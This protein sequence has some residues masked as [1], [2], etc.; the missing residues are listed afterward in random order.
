MSSKHK[1]QKDDY[2][3]EIRKIFFIA[4]VLSVN[5]GLGWS[6]GLL[7]TAEFPRPVY[8]TF[9]YLFSI[10]VGMQGVLI[11]ILHCART[12]A[13]REI[14][15]RW[16]LVICMCKRPEE[17]K[18]ITRQMATNTGGGTPAISRK[19]APMA[20]PSRALDK[21]AIPLYMQHYTRQ[22]S[23][24]D[25]GGPKRNEMYKNPVHGLDDM[26]TE[27]RMAPSLVFDDID[28]GKE[29]SKIEE[30]FPR[31]DDN[32]QESSKKLSKKESK[33]QLRKQESTQLRK[34]ESK[35]LRKQESKQLRKQESKQLWKQESKQLWKQDS[36]S[37]ANKIQ[38]EEKTKRL[39]KTKTE[40]GSNLK[41]LHEDDL[42]GSTYSLGEVSLTGS[43]ALEIEFAPSLD[44]SDD[45]ST[46]W[47][48]LEKQF[49]DIGT[50]DNADIFEE[51][52]TENNFFY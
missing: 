10:F 12:R 19:P 27:T 1:K 43:E 45:E 6:F 21:H 37:E 11:F 41:M 46:T 40:S 18:F 28:I 15:T 47:I 35:Q 33:Q 14:W 49:A 36:K 13:A 26:E 23:K 25:M 31:Y 32:E 30:Q 5:F 16:I 20:K 2:S 50:L 51:F 4:I 44:A 9:V 34:Q 42:A 17:A 22:T 29:L 38:T 24:A 7:G 39:V 3:S 52:K 8:L 48:D